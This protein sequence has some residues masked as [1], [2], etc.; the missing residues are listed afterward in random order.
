MPRPTFPYLEQHL[1]NRFNLIR[2]SNNPNSVRAVVVNS[3]DGADADLIG[4]FPNLEIV[5]CY[6]VGVDKI[7]TGMCKEKRIRVTNTPDVLTDE[8][9]D[10]AIALILALLRKLPACDQFVRN[11]H[12]KNGDF[13]L[14]T[15]VLSVHP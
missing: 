3:V 4:K 9:A 10:L 5:S 8:T 2:H 12:W 1:Q 11:G 13:N 15:K 6:G 7:D 14:T